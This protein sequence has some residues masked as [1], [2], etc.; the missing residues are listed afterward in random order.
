ML[1]NS[2][3]ARITT[4]LF[5]FEP[6]GGKSTLENP[7]STSRASSKNTVFA[8]ITPIHSVFEPFGGEIDPG[9]S[10]FDVENVTNTCAE[11]DMTIKN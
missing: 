5:V 10:E 11:T 6:F 7:Y 1:K 2:D 8:R 9:K 4:K 3:F